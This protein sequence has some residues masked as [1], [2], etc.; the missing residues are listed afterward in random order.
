[1]TRRIE[2]QCK[3]WAAVMR[4][5]AVLL[6]TEAV[7][8]P[9][10]APDLARPGDH[11]ISLLA[12]Q[13]TENGWQQIILGDDVRFPDAY[14]T[15]VMLSRRFAHLEDWAEFDV[16]G[17]VVR[18]VGDQDH[19]EFNAAVLARWMQL[20]W[21]RW[22]PT[23]AGFGL[24][25]SYATQEPA[26]EVARSGSS[27]KLLLYWVAELEFSQPDQPWSG[28]IRLHH[29]SNVYGLVAEHGASNAVVLGL[30]RRF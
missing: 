3:S 6:A 21:N 13:M 25:F 11:A 24:G 18:H 30:R 5:T 29:R 16:E 2:R 10:E 22:L 4:A 8:Q 14:L 17:Q 20:P 19:W 28:F 26:V 27:A 1:M 15:G 7:A 9:I 12:G 23:H